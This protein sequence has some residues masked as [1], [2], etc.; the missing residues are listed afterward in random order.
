MYER[1][2]ETQPNFG[3]SNVPTGSTSVNVG[4]D[5]GRKA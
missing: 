1:Y 4:N 3:V 5:H 2:A